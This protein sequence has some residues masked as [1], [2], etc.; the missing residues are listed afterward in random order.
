MSTFAIA[1]AVIGGIMGFV[2]GTSGVLGYNKN[3]NKQFLENV[4]KATRQYNLTQNELDKEAVY[5]RDDASNSLYQVSLNAFRNNALVEAA[6]GESGVEGRSQK[7]ISR[8]VSGQSERQKDNIQASYENTIYSIKT[9]K[10]SLFIEYENNVNNM[11]DMVKAQYKKGMSAVME[12]ADSTAQGA[13]MGY[14]GGAAI[15]AMG[16][17][18]AAAGGTAAGAGATGAGTAAGATAGTTAGA[19]A[20]TAGAGAAGTAAS[21]TGSF[22]GTMGQAWDKV[23]SYMK[24][25]YA[26][27]GGMSAFETP[28]YG[29]VPYYGTSG[30]SSRNSRRIRGSYY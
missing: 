17:A 15:G 14:L 29:N 12:I 28:Q 7:A 8:D 22:W 26:F 2:G 10:D 11:R 24:Y 6:L 16:S 21:T 25:Y 30:Y 13:A 9:K 5:A 19:T 1:G 20:G 3:L 4:K 18:G 23:S 27:K